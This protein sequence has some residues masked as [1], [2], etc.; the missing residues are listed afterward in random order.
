M[1]LCL[2]RSR[3]LNILAFLRCEVFLPPFH[4]VT[5]LRFRKIS[6]SAA[7][8]FY[9]RLSLDDFKLTSMEGHCPRIKQ[10]YS[11]LHQ[12]EPPIDILCPRPKTPFTF[13]PLRYL[14]SLSLS[15]FF[16]CTSRIWK[17][18]GQGLDPSCSCN[19]S[20]AETMWDPQTAAPQR[21][22]LPQFLWWL[23]K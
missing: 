7:Q 13:P 3:S 23:K 15:F 6:K 5:H 10:Q 21:P 22:L 12:T 16:S 2:D 11:W 9:H 17:F 18:P 4:S 20:A 14:L 1:S 19:A 8:Y